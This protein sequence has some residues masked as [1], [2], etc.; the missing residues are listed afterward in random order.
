MGPAQNPSIHAIM[1]APLKELPGLVPLRSLSPNC[2]P[3]DASGSAGD[4][5]A[6]AMRRAPGFPLIAM[7][8]PLAIVKSTQSEGK[9]RGVNAT[10]DRVSATLPGLGAGWIDQALPSQLQ[11]KV[12]SML[13]LLKKCPAALQEVAA[14]Q[15]T[16]PRKAS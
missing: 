10:A 2:G 1:N 9:T 15:E 11:A 12:S 5:G 8:S 3:R 16:A 4:Q 13:L 7:R 6:T 14:G